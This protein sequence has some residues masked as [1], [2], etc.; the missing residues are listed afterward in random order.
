VKKPCKDTVWQNVG[1]LGI[2]FPCPHPAKYGE[3][4]GIHSPEKKAERAARRGPTRYERD[5]TA[6]QNRED[7]KALVNAALD[8]V[9]QYARLVTEDSGLMDRTI[10][11][12]LKRSIKELDAIT[13]RGD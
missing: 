7:R 9:L 5:C 2:T 3:Y 8:K 4:C 11:G 6:R 1:A 13:S 10:C 12:S